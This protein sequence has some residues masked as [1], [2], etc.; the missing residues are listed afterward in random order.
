MEGWRGLFHHNQ[1]L[2]K[3]KSFKLQHPRFQFYLSSTSNQIWS[4]VNLTEG[5]MQ[6]KWGENTL[7]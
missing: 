6:Y 3:L 5:S 1:I 2:G 4:V 7:F